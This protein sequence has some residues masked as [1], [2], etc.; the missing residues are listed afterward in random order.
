MLNL[1]IIDDTTATTTVT[2]WN[3]STVGSIGYKQD[4]SIGF[5]G[6]SAR[7]A[8]VVTNSA[9]APT[10][11]PSSVS[12]DALPTTAVTGAYTGG[13]WTGGTW[14]AISY[15]VPAG[16]YYLWIADGIYNAS[17]NTTS[18]ATGAYQASLKVG[19]LQAISAELGVVQIATNGS[20]Y[21]GRTT[22][23]GTISAGFFLGD[24]SGTKKFSIGTANNAKGLLWDG[25]DLQLRMSGTAGIKLFNS[26]TSTVIGTIN[27]DT[28]LGRS[29]L[30][31]Q[32]EID[33][34]AIRAKNTSGYGSSIFIVDP[35]AS[36]NTAMWSTQPVVD[37]AAVTYR[38]NRT[39]N[40]Y[41]ATLAAT[42][43]NTSNLYLQAGNYGQ[44]GTVYIEGS[45]ISLNAPLTSTS[46]GAFTS[47][48]VTSTSQVANLNAS[49]LLG[50]TWASPG[51]IGG[52]TPAAITTT[53][54]TVTTNGILI[55]NA[56]PGI[57]FYESDRGS[58]LKRWL[59]VADGELF[60]LQTR[61]DA[62]AAVATPL[63]IDRSGNMTVLGETKT[64]S[65]RIQQTPV[66]NGAAAAT[67][68]G[69]T[70][71]GAASTNMWINISCNGTTY[72]IPVW[73]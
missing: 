73:T 49:L 50:N 55:N 60:Q 54:L 65:F 9:S 39:N 52:T 31:L 25:T 2:N 40:T 47:I 42:P 1:T 5:T 8:Y 70:K 61:T 35:F 41:I 56:S 4:G 38:G 71:P 6:G 26:V 58:N 19:N 3:L 64:T 22:A 12:G 36:T 7:R 23:E 57:S 17:T 59:L 34:L 63:L 15:A 14:Q 32:S 68:V 33:Y 10:V 45:A 43:A 11:A 28:I 27:V 53:G 44:N 16:S 46:T 37:G 69:T 30:N 18:W 67:F 29:A 66:N 24:Q 20:L 21:S 13:S 48:T 51:T 72:Y 62:D